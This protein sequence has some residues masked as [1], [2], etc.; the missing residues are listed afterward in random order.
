M[1]GRARSLTIRHTMQK[2]RI[3]KAGLPSSRYNP[4]D[5]TVLKEGSTKFAFVKISR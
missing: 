5:V 3:V 2:G 1:T 4:S